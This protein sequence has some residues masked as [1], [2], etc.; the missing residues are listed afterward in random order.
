M[1]DTDRKDP[2]ANRGSNGTVAGA[3][4]PHAREESGTFEVDVAPSDLLVAL[5]RL[6]LEAALAYEA[7]ASLSTEPEVARQLRAFAK[8]HRRHLGE[9]NRVLEE[10]GERGVAATA[11]ETPVLAGI[12]QV[13]GPLGPEVTVVALLGDEQLTNLSYDAALA[14][15]WDAEMEA[16]LE[17]FAA[18]E[19][20]HLAWLVERHDAVAE[21][22]HG[23][24]RPGA[25]E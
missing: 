19:R 13:A 9:L 1:A 22:A 4:S 20:R 16:M 15:S 10:D 24:D 18:D 8:D 11:R 25:P 21:H 14:Y 17:R 23:A 5:A 7:A 2:A 6:D 12:I 3:P